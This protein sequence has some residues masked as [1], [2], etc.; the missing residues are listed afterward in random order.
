[1]AKNF[2][3]R[4]KKIILCKENSEKTT[5]TGVREV[6]EK[7]KEIK[8]KQKDEILV[9]GDLHGNYSQWS[10]VKERIEKNPNTYVIILGDAIDRGHD[11]IKILTEIKKLSDQGKA[12][13]IPG[14]HDQMAYTTLM[15][16]DE[17]KLEDTGYL[18]YLSKSWELNEG[19]TKSTEQQLFEIGYTNPKEYE[20]IMEWWGKQPIQMKLTADTNGQKTNYAFA[21]AAFDEELFIKRPN[22]CLKEIA[23]IWSGLEKNETDEIIRRYGNEKTA[24]ELGMRAMNYSLWYREK[25]P[26]ITSLMKKF[27]PKHLADQITQLNHTIPYNEIMV[28]GHTKQQQIN[29]KMIGEYFPTVYIDTH[30][31]DMNKEA[32]NKLEIYNVTTGKSELLEKENDRER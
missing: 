32:S 19:K 26:E 14:N 12:R 8:E 23:E 18:R 27:L 28:V 29:V 16:N 17:R 5:T 30:A 1:M 2:L 21:H 7:I 20:E 15:A 4:L 24:L 11:S 6:A 25:S 10:L 13:Y 9:V 31:S 3:E 22:I